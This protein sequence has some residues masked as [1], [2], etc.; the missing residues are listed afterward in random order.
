MF[1]IILTPGA[2]ARCP[3][4]CESDP[5]P[6]YDRFPWLPRKFIILS[7]AAFVALSWLGLIW[8]VVG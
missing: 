6:N 3:V 8:L 4:N 1:G 7:A 2:P 5:P